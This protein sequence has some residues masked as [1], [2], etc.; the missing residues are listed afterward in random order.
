MNGFDFSP[1]VESAHNIGI[2]HEKQRGRSR[3]QTT[4]KI[5]TRSD[6]PTLVHQ[7][8][9]VPDAQFVVR[10]EDRVFCQQMSA[11]EM[12]AMVL[13]QQLLAVMHM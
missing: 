3:E 8:F 10:S 12:H 5:W 2:G 6:I 4:R 1:D 13:L 7:I 9:N 11:S